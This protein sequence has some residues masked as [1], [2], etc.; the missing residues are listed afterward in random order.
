MKKFLVNVSLVVISTIIAL[1]IAESGAR[2]VGIDP[3]THKF[4]SYKFDETIGWVT[5]KNFKYYRSSLYFGHF[6][7]YDQYGFPTGHSTMDRTLSKEDPTFAIIGDSFA[8]AYFVPYEASI[9]GVLERKFPDHQI[10]TMGVGGH[11]P[12]QTY[13]YTKE[14]LDQFTVAKAAILFF[15]FNDIRAVYDVDFQGYNKPLFEDP[16]GEPVN[17]PLRD[18]TRIEEEKTIIQKILHNSALYS[19]ARPL[20][21]AKIKY[22]LISGTNTPMVFKADQMRKAL[23]FYDRMQK[24]NPKTDFTVYY[25]PLLEELQ[26]QN[27]VG[28]NVTMFNILCADIGI[29]CEMIW[30]PGATPVQ[31]NYITGDGHFSELGNKNVAEFISEKQFPLEN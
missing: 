29:K 16:Y 22:R 3:N 18:D 14:Y 11:S 6:N 10:V 24:E 21:R 9:A 1:I 31:D 12:D 4:T 26:D 8:E 19:T 30:F 23:L 13:L 25:V 20:I 7:Y 28:K 5:R 27:I 15:P 2:L 17:L